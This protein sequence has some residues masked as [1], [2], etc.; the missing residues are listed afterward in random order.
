MQDKR[1]IEN[2][3]QEIMGLV[4]EHG[5]L[6]CENNE[7][8]HKYR[9]RKIESKLRELAENSFYVLEP[10]NEKLPKGFLADVVTA[11]GL[12][13]HGKQS[14]ALGERLAFAVMQIRTN[15]ITKDS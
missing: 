10:L 2:V 9:E 6:C 7:L 11:A 4:I 14:K 5:E 3:V 8:G 15:N 1:N 12:V 13:E